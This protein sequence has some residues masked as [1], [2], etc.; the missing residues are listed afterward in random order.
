MWSSGVRIIRDH[1]WT[2]VG[3]G[4]MVADHMRII[5]SLTAR[6]IPKDALVIYI[7]ISSR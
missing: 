4:A 1:P 2:G 6:L 5:E 3:M 7:T